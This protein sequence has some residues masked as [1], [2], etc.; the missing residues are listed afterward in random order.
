MKENNGNIVLVDTT[1][2]KYETIKT[3]YLVL[4]SIVSTGSPE[5]W[6]LS[7][8]SFK[9]FYK[10]EKKGSNTFFVLMLSSLSTRGCLHSICKALGVDTTILDEALLINRSISCPSEESAKSE[11]DELLKENINQIKEIIS[12]AEIFISSYEECL[13][14]I[15]ELAK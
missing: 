9:N 1:R 10:I 7:G 2:E 14:K 5:P 13:K 8:N 4:A 15:S 11:I 6:Q 3:N 12:S